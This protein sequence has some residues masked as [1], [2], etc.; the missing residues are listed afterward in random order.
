MRSVMSSGFMFATGIECSY[1][2]VP[3]GK[4]GSRRVD[5]M[6]WITMNSDM[7]FAPGWPGINRARPPARKQGWARP[8]PATAGSGLR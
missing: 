1:P 8:S 5:E 2:T 7:R 3:D 6:A 4:G